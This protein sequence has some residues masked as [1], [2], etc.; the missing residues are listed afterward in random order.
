[1]VESG[2]SFSDRDMYRQIDTKY[3]KPCLLRENKVRWWLYVLKGLSYEHLVLS[4]YVL[5]IAN[6]MKTVVQ[7]RNWV[8]LRGGRRYIY[9]RKDEIIYALCPSVKCVKYIGKIGLS[10]AISSTSMS[11]QETTWLI[12]WLIRICLRSN[13]YLVRE[14]KI[15]LSIDISSTSMTD[16]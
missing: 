6:A 9:S 2:F 15:G 3:I 13:K 11:T 4:Y 8:I 10:N 14:S 12:I 5:Q 1:M 7:G 16:W